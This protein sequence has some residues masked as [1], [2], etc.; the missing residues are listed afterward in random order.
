MKDR[1][2]DILC[3]I[4]SERIRQIEMERFTVAHDD[5]HNALELARAAGA[6]VQH[7]FER[8]WLIT[9]AVTPEAGL[10]TYRG[11]PA[12]DC[13]PWDEEYWKPKNPRRDLIRAIALLVAEVE[14][15]DRKSP[16]TQ[17]L[18]DPP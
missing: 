10:R 12:P 3:E 6:Y 16:H 11:D 17:N 5:D 8:Q 4:E 9:D 14:R 7:Y 1:T 2:S 13:W 18:K 15:M